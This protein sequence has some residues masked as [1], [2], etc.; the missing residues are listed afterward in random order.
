M[1]LTVVSVFTLC[2]LPLNTL[3]VVG[4]EYDAIWQFG[5]IQYVWFVCHWLAMSSASYN[6]VI[7]CWM[8][9]KYRDGFRYVFRRMLCCCLP[10]GDQP[11]RRDGFGRGTNNTVYTSIRSARGSQSSSHRG[12]LVVKAKNNHEEGLL[13]PLHNGT[14]LHAK[15]Y[16]S[17]V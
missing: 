2:W 4:D 14:T 12:S 7:Y 13:R 3:I 6:P 9:S 16:V 10:A 17:K 11:L 15:D 8:N 1:M 5:H